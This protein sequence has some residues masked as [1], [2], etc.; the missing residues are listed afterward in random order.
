MGKFR[1]AVKGRLSL[2]LPKMKPLKFLILAWDGAAPKIIFNHLNQLPTLKRLCQ[3]GS[4]G[5]V[6]SQTGSF[7]VWTTYYTGLSPERHGIKQVK[8]RERQKEGQLNLYTLNDV[9]CRKFLWNYINETG[10]SIGM[11]GGLMTY[12]APQ[13]KGFVVSGE[14][15]Y[16]KK[17]SAFFPPEIRK[18]VPDT[19][20]HYSVP[21]PL[22][23]PFEQLSNQEIENILLSGYFA[24]LPALIQKIQRN[25]E[26]AT[27]LCRLYPVDILIHYFIDLDPI[28]HFSFHEPDLGTI[29]RAYQIMDQG[30]GKFIATFQPQWVMVVSDHGGDSFQ[31]IYGKSS[32]LEE[33]PGWKRVN[34]DLLVMEG[35]NKAIISGDHIST[36]FYAIWGPK[37][38]KNCRWQISFTDVFP[39]ILHA[40]KIPLPEG[41][42]GRI[43]DIFC[44]FDQKRAQSYN[45]LEWVVQ[46][47]YLRR[48]IEFA[49]L[50]PADTVLDLGTGTGM[51]ACSVAPKVKKVIGID[52]SEHMLKEA[53][54]QSPHLSFIRCDARKLPFT[55]KSF[56][57]V[58][59]R[60]VFHHITQD[61]EHAVS[62]CFRVLKQGGALVVSEGV[63]PCPEVKPEYMQ[64]F[65][66]K[67]NRLTFLPEDLVLLLEQAGFFGI[68]YET[69]LMPRVSVKNW[70]EN[71]GC[72]KHIQGK[73]M[74][75]HFNSSNL[76]KKVYEMQISG[77]DC[78]ID[79]RFLVVKGYKPE[80]F[81]KD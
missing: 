54:K 28:Q 81:K 19:I 22:A 27:N 11:V 14:L 20:F 42:D 71:S 48:F 45:Q 64:I 16:G 5:E 3:E 12:P 4:C 34:Q 68:C 29:L 56:D 6:L 25:L 79:M 58:L 69:Y 50:K 17:E 41:L 32:E 33:R 40:L 35:H 37:V 78:L 18:F 10:Y 74:Q 80:K 61:L 43:P 72:P 38:S 70:L 65:Q 44:D 49:D 51:V 59:A 39:M 55:D 73:I 47:Q 30:L 9:C 66:L 60:M 21:A 26:M 31:N 15:L 7:D 63:P 57:K 36:G 13:V 67:E 46:D 8:L 52:R 53:K 23:K 77:D 2:A 1:L 62:E 76:F 75:L 24:P